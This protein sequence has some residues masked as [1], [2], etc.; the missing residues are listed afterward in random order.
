VHGQNDLEEELD[1]IMEMEIP[2][3][4]KYI[5]KL[6][7]TFSALQVIRGQHM[8]F[9]FSKEA[10]LTDFSNFMQKVV[11]KRT[12]SVDIEQ[13]RQENNRL[14]NASLADV[15]A[16]QVSLD[17]IYYGTDMDKRA[18]ELRK[19]LI[20]SGFDVDLDLADEGT[21][22]IIESVLEKFD[23]QKAIEEEDAIFSARQMQFERKR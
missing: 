22:D 6:T 1:V 15:L 11:K 23:P 10:D 7:P 8:G 9:L 13:L 14:S 20:L 3:N 18:N 5:P 2:L 17:E 21:M 19:I 12:C 4:F 16:S